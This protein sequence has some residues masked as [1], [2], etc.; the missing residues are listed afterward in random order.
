MDKRHNKFIVRKGR[1][2]FKCIVF[3]QKHR[4]VLQVCPLYPRIW[5]AAS[6]EIF[7]G[8]GLWVQI[9]SY[10]LVPIRRHVPINSHASRHWK[11]IEAS[12]YVSME[13]VTIQLKDTPTKVYAIGAKLFFIKGAPRSASK[14]SIDPI[15]SHASYIGKNTGSNKRNVPI[16]RNMS[17]NWNQRVRQI[18]A[19]H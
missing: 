5:K 11:S 16:N 12:V 8:S 18:E 3:H 13:K 6:W 4:N 2:C 14:L 19:K 10:P 17:S 15:N 9:G 1:G 7:L